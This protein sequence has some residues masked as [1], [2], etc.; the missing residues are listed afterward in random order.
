MV[1][2]LAILTPFCAAGA[3]AAW[4]R[5]CRSTGDTSALSLPRAAFAPL[6]DA[7]LWASAAPVSHARLLALW[8]WRIS[9]AYCPRKIAVP[10]PKKCTS[11]MMAET[12]T[13][14][15]SVKSRSPNGGYP[16]TFAQA[17][18]SSMS[19]GIPRT[20]LTISIT[21]LPPTAASER[22]D[23]NLPITL[24]RVHMNAPYQRIPQKETEP[25][26]GSLFQIS[27]RAHNRLPR[28]QPAPAP[29]SVPTA[30]ALRSPFRSPNVP[31]TPQRTSWPHNLVQT[32]P[33]RAHVPRKKRHS[34]ASPVPSPAPSNPADV[35]SLPHACAISPHQ[36]GPIPQFRQPP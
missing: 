16:S 36:S 29:D 27:G 18:A 6:S 1:F 5:P 11:T 24:S 2:V 30:I 19:P 9:W 25:C 15:F 22:P 13:R 14:T 31:R 17:P 23:I 21:D 28:Q 35:P 3:C 20:S 10:S 8:A 12:T 32:R 33:T 34:R 26:G 4:D 7:V